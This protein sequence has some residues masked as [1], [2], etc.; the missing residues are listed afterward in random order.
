MDLSNLKLSDSSTRML[1]R[2]PDTDEIIYID[3]EHEDPMHIDLISSDAKEY[4][5]LVHRQNNARMKEVK[6]VRNKI[7]EQ[8]T[9]F[10]DDRVAHM[11]ES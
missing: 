7:R 1:L 8:A 4:R 6:V 10:V 9:A 5:S 11:G 2:N 3:D